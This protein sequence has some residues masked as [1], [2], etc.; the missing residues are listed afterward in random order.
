MTTTVPEIVQ[1]ELLPLLQN[2][3]R[4]I[5]YPGEDRFEFVDSLD[6]R[7]LAI[8][9]DA[10]HER[11]IDLYACRDIAK[12]LAVRVQH[13]DR[14]DRIRPFLDALW[15]VTRSRMDEIS[16][17]LR[18][19]G[20]GGEWGNPHNFNDEMLR[21]CGYLEKCGCQELLLNN[22]IPE[23]QAISIFQLATEKAR[24]AK[25]TDA[26]L[27]RVTTPLQIRRIKSVRKKR[28]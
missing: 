27:R 7:M 28:R 10:L 15:E 17:L 19:A 24:A 25:W 2:P 6:K 26:L 22:E 8:L 18:S 3:H 4:G 12:V 21:R 11:D 5:S 1:S 9:L 13:Q 23:A 20:F 16:K 14:E